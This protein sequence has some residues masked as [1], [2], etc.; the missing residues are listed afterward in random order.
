MGRPDTLGADTYHNRRFPI[1]D[2]REA[3]DDSGTCEMLE[4]PSCSIIKCMVDFSRITKDICQ[5]IYLS[6]VTVLRTVHLAY[7]IESNLEQWIETLPEEIRPTELSGGLPSLSKARDQQ[8]M[9]RQR[10]V[11]S[12]SSSA[13]PESAAEKYLID[14]A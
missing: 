4:H 10:L 3:V 12:L 2:S 8:W 7:Q 1:T 11:L 6:G 9:K 14:W 5:N 13:V